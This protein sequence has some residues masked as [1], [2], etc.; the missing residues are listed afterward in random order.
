MKFVYKPEGLAPREWE[1]EPERQLMSAECI[2]IEKLTGMEWGEWKAA[3]RKESMRA[4]HAYLWVLL[5]RENPTLLPK[6]VSFAPD[7][8]VFVPSDD[9]VRKVFDAFAEKPD[10]DW[11][12]ED[13]EN[14]AQLRE[15]YP[16]LIPD[17]TP[18]DADELGPDALDDE[19]D[20][21]IPDPKG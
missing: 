18:A 7:E 9:E 4:K 17:E 3:V 19:P 2:A 12:D 10:T 13:R 11:D 5:K 21:V 1:F 15:E 14:Y 6:H 8:A 16:H 20:E